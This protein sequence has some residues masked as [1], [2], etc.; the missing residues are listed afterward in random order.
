MNP[1]LRLPEMAPYVLPEDDEPIASFNSRR[2]PE[3]AIHL[4][5]VPE[6]YLGDP[7]APVVLLNLNPGFVDD[8]RTVH[9]DT[10]FNAAARANL[11]HAHREWPLYLLDR[12]LPNSPGQDWWRRKLS[13][14]VN[15]VGSEQL[16]AANLFV[17]ELHGYHSRRFHHGLAIPSQQYTFSLVKEA[18]QRGAYF[19]VMRGLKQWRNR[20]PEL[21]TASLTQLRNPQNPVISPGNCPEHFDALVRA[22]H[23]AA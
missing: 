5:I 18:I 8:D 19:V 22:I 14:L 11:L 3:H 23:R 20:L 2:R 9:L 21:S 15:A 17:A 10:A 7:C 16:V 13:A 6:P 1:W 12:S 4:E